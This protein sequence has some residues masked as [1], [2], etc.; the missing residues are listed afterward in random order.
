[1]FR[2]WCASVFACLCL[3]VRVCMCPCVC[4]CVCDCVLGALDWGMLV[5]VVLFVLVGLCSQCLC[6]CVCVLFVCFAGLV[7]GRRYMIVPST[8]ATKQRA[9]SKTEATRGFAIVAPPDV[10][11]VTYICI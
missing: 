7:F 11:G 6:V 8:K 3:C 1:M 5:C 10:Q 9:S 4:V 2:G